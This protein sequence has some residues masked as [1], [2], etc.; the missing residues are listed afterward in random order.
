MTTLAM[1]VG[2]TLVGLCLAVAVL[3]ALYD[4]ALERQGDFRF[5][6]EALSQ[7]SDPALAITWE[8][9]ATPLDR[10]LTDVDRAQVG[11]ALGA[12]WHALA[13][14]Q[15]AGRPDLLVDVFIGPALERARQS[16]ADASAHGGRIAILSQ[17]VT[18]LFF[19][20]DGTLLQLDI[21]MTASRFVTGSDE[22][23]RH[24]EVTTDRTRVTLERQTMGWRIL[25]VERRESQILQARAPRPVPLGLRGINYYPA[26]TPWSAFWANYDPDQ[27]TRDLARVR[28]LGANTVRIFL[29]Q[30]AFGDTETRAAALEHLR[31]FLTAADAAGLW[32]MPTLFD[33]RDGYGPG[34]WAADA[35]WLGEV[36]PVLA[37]APAVVAVDIKNEPDLDF[38][39][40]GEA[41]VTAWLRTMAALC[42]QH[43]PGLALTVGWSRAEAAGRLTDV[44]DLVTYHDYA[45]TGGAA[46][47]LEMVRAAA[48]GRP[49]MVTEIGASAFSLLAGWPGSPTRQADHLTQMAE[50][51]TAA[52]GVLIWTLYD[53]AE[54]DAAAVGRSPWVRRLQENYGLFTTD[55]VE[56]P[57]AAAARAV[58][59][60]W[61]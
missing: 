7:V 32:V 17:T 20:A 30:G 56:K 14:A 49:V 39:T 47:R 9:P 52:D 33:M 22:A 50:G 40:H 31:H 45:A 57:A 27:T 15:A 13:T 8:A 35:V 29:G 36:L 24:H 4:R 51:L 37:A 3:A 26:A 1:R 18:P 43:A 16:V 46:E 48:L 53:F 19:H 11:R 54:A 60:R 58:F 12:G 42:H 6:A 2:A 28:D 21:A 10:A 61:P 55:G 38:E 44:L 59:S 41:L 34:G 5:I 25:S 23:L